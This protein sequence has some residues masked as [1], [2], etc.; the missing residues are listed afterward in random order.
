M[1]TSVHEFQKNHQ[2]K[3]ESD[4]QR[5]ATVTNDEYATLS[6]LLQERESINA[7]RAAEMA[8]RTF[9]HTS[10]TKLFI[11]ICALNFTVR[12]FLLLLCNKTIVD[13]GCIEYGVQFIRKYQ[14]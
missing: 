1:H 14:Y 13:Y 5:F 3:I 10:M 2:H 11:S 4:Q 6:N 7:R 8:V 12:Q 9:D